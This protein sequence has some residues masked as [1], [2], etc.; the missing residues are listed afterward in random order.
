MIQTHAYPGTAKP[1]VFR[2][3]GENA[4]INRYGLQSEGCDRVAIRLRTRVRE[5]TR[6]VGLGIDTEAE[7]Y[8]LDGKAGVPR[9][10]IPGKL[11]AVQVSKK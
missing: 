10:L 11:L 3:P 8:V 1:R 6:Q 9:S 2:V 4:L 7:K 5:F